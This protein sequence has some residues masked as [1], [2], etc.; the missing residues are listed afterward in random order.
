MLH[1]FL[2]PLVNEVMEVR[3]III[4]W[5]MHLYKFQYTNIRCYVRNV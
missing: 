5:M 4:E 3:E 2:Q 1:I